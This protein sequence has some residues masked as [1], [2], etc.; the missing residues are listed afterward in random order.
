MQNP[1]I[2]RCTHCDTGF[3]LLP[4]QLEAAQ[5]MV[6]CGACR[7]VFNA[8]DRL[9][10][11]LSTDSDSALIDSE[12]STLIHDDL[13]IDLD[14]PNFH[15]E[16][17]RLATEEPL[18]PAPSDIVF[19]AIE[20]AEE[21]QKPTFDEEAWA[22]AILAEESDAISNEQDKAAKKKEPSVGGDIGAIETDPLEFIWQPKPSKW[23]RNLL[24][25]LLILIAL[26]GL[27]GQYVYFNFDS[28]VRN[29]SSRIWLQR[30]CPL[31]GC[32]LPAQVNVEHIKA[33]NLIVRKHPEFQDALLIDAVIYNRAPYVQAYPLIKLNFLDDA[34]TVLA[35]RT[36]SP[37]EYL[38]GELAG[39][40]QMPAQVPIRIAFEVL[41]PTRMATNHSLEFLSP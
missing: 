2:T 33:S 28:L 15:N 5:G 1:L 34:N 22:K 20:E 39:S 40:Q 30:I 13:E 19:S 18:Q 27:V 35:S 26:G 23:K 16:L 7:T 3:H 41:L 6:R 29:D 12:D 8:F 4:E 31:V 14:D 21:P 38:G 11:S 17:T 36:F 25:S 37:V 32:S 10:M 9:D 24:W